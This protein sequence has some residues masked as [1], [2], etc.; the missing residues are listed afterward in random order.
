MKLFLPLLFVGAILLSS[1]ASKRNYNKAQKFDE[2]GLYTD[3][4]ALYL[5]SL[6]ANKNNI[7]AKLGL[8]RT[9]QLVLEDKVEVFQNQYNNGGV[10]EAVYAYREAESYYNQLSA[11]GVK[12]IMSDEQRE[13]YLEVKDKYL[14]I[15]YQQASK[16]L[17]L[18]EFTS[19]ESQFKEIL[20]IDKNFKDAK[21]QWVIA[22]YEPVYRHGNQLMET[23]Q[24]RSAYA[25]FNTINSATKGYK[26]SL[27]LQNTCLQEA[28]VSIAI[29]PVT[30][31][32]RSYRYYTNNVE[33]Q[34]VTELSK[35]KSPFYKVISKDAITSVP[36]WSSAKDHEMAIKFARKIGTF[37]AKSVLA[38]SI[39]RYVRQ[40]GKLNKEEKRGYLKELVEVTNKE[41]GLKE[42]KAKY[43][44]VRYYEYKQ[45][46]VASIT[47]RFDLDRIDK[48]EL[49]LSDSYSKE[50]KSAVHYAKF[51]GDYQ[52]LVPGYW[53]YADKESAEDQIYDSEQAVKQLHALFKANK[54][55]TS[56]QKLEEIVLKDCA[57]AV[58]KSIQSYQPEN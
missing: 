18:D 29:L 23:S 34:V 25:D 46:N 7:D 26:N 35:I 21:S 36:N 15:L 20:S 27:E 47:L 37:E 54:E 10:K 43:R 33:N 38:A 40:S 58:A 31:K 32:Y 9:G 50:E 17:S 12:L 39:D 1:C 49:A 4:A 19:A 11:L 42:I 51:D 30:Y 2:A 57:L 6:K 16:A 41:T 14:D 45:S 8:Q 56:I 5:K 28:T 13:Y 48:E 22:K 3:A 55:A 52:K 24:F 44:K 53:K